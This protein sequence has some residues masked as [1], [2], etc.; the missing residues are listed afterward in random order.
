MNRAGPVSR[1]GVSL[2]GS[3][4]VCLTQQKSTLR[5]H[6]NRASPVI[7]DPGIAVP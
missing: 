4:H 5:L 1:A 6:D 2:L 7:R 3:Q